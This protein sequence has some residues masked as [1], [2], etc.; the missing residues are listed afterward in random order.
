[1]VIVEYRIAMYKRGLLE[2]NKRREKLN[3]ENV[4]LR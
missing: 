1:M 2:M 4:E 3:D